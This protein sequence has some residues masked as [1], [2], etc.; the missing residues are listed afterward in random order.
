MLLV[1][2]GTTIPWRLRKDLATRGLYEARQQD[3]LFTVKSVAADLQ[4]KCTVVH[5]YMLHA[6]VRSSGPHPLRKVARPRIRGGRSPHAPPKA[7]CHHVGGSRPCTCHQQNHAPTPPSNIPRLD[8]EAVSMK[9]TAITAMV[10]ASPNTL[11]A[12]M[13]ALLLLLLQLPMLLLGTCCH[14]IMHF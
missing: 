6:F 3:N 12:T 4:A 7:N 9:T 5:C 14:A 10:I 1:A 13:T 11:I 2:K 8:R